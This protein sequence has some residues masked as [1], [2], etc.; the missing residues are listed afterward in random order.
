MSSSL[1]VSR[2]Q[3]PSRT[4]IDLLTGHVRSG[5]GRGRGHRRARA[6]ADFGG[7]GRSHLHG[8]S[9][10]ARRTAAYPPSKNGKPSAVEMLLGLAVA[11]FIEP[12]SSE[13]LTSALR[14]LSPSGTEHGAHEPTLPTTQPKLANDVPVME[15]HSTRV[16]GSTCKHAAIP[17][18]LSRRCDWVVMNETNEGLIKYRSPPR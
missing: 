3:V 13:P 8:P 5:S 2:S 17:T 14:E 1:C 7:L 6:H 4:S 11:A 18:G 10:G 15:L 12:R 9:A 16:Q